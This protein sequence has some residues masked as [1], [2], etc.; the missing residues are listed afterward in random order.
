MPDVPRPMTA[1]EKKEAQIQSTIKQIKE[2][3]DLTVLKTFEKLAMSNHET[4]EAFETRL[5]ELQ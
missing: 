4:K 5:K 1:K 2:I 3:T